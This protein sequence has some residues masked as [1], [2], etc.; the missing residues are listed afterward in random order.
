MVNS[1]ATSESVED[2]T[3]H[4]KIAA[5]LK[6]LDQKELRAGKRHEY[7]TKLRIRLQ[8]RIDERQT[9]VALGENIKIGPTV[10]ELLR[11]YCLKNDQ[12][13]VEECCCILYYLSI[14]DPHFKK[15]VARLFSAM[16]QYPE[17]TA[18]QW[19]ALAAIQNVVSANPDSLPRIAP[20]MPVI[21]TAMKTH[22]G[23][24]KLQDSAIKVLANL[25]CHGPSKVKFFN[26]TN[27]TDGSR[28]GETDGAIN[29]ILVAMESHLEDITIQLCGFRALANLSADSPIEMKQRIYDI[30]VID[31]ILKG[32][33]ANESNAKMQLYGCYTIA[34]VMLAAPPSTD[35]SSDG[36]GNNKDTN[37][38][39]STSSGSG[40]GNGGGS[41]AGS[42]TNNNA[43]G[44]GGG[45]NGGG[46]PALS[47]LETLQSMVDEKGAL[48]VVLNAMMDHSKDEQVQT[49]GLKALSYFVVDPMK[50]GRHA[51][52]IQEIHEL[53]F[54]E[55]GLDVVLYVMQLPFNSL[56]IAQVGC[57]ILRNFTRASLDIQRA[58][59]AKGGMHVVIQAMK[60]HEMNYKVQ[61]NGFACMRNLCVHT[62]NRLQAK[63]EGAIKTLL[64]NMTIWS[65]DAAIQAYGCDALGRLA[66]EIDNQQII[67]Q[68]HGIYVAIKAMQEHPN[69]PGVQDRAIFMLLQ[70]SEYKPALMSMKIK[71]ILPIL[72]SSKIPQQKQAA[73][74]RLN[75]L[76]SLVEKSGWFS[77]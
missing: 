36:T 39:S 16:K 48:L 60:R 42:P 31:T 14:M 71:K 67:E 6:I 59:S 34:N 11:Q 27:A 45:A 76:M 19:A 24:S 32:M 57:E 2:R 37:N 26:I 4:Q 7:L 75:K 20:S 54:S 35:G 28:G 62:D 61:D 64:T 53:F 69:H 58:V 72:Q 12:K 10:V 22:I 3:D 66:S 65:K 29:Q 52:D 46:V 38:V 33:K 77:G 41:P 23:H 13:V 51:K 43:G 9:R 68:E 18:I 40:S 73:V 47:S 30:G 63:E 17:N 70:L 49:R 74:E 8:E 50:Y 1:V 25:A 21:I 44:G 55:G 15:G 56:Q 5:Y